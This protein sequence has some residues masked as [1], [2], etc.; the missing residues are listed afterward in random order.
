MERN[1]Y[2]CETELKIFKLLLEGRE[3]VRQGESRERGRKEDRE[4]GKKEEIK[5]RRKKGRGWEDGETQNEW[6]EKK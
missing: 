5:E 2:I 6:G 4:R 3:N 1:T